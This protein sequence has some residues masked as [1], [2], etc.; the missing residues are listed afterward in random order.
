MHNPFRRPRQ[1]D[2]AAMHALQVRRLQAELDAARLTVAALRADIEQWQ[3][4]CAKAVEA[5]VFYYQAYC[6]NCRKEGKHQ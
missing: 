3:C 1:P 4:E 6:D 5:Q 2:A